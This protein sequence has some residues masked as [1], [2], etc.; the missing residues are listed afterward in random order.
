MLKR[1]WGG[2]L[3]KRFVENTIRIR[4][5]LYHKMGGFA[6]IFDL[7]VGILCLIKCYMTGNVIW[8]L[9]L[10]ERNNYEKID[11]DFFVGFF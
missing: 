4:A 8:C 2:R 11:F 7:A 5:G 10:N 3:I 9:T 1:P 6:K